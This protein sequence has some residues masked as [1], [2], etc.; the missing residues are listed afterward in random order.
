GEGGSP[1]L[2]PGTD[3]GRVCPKALHDAEPLGI[4]SPSPRGRGLGIGIE[5]LLYFYKY[6]LFLQTELP[7]R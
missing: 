2:S 4:H 1:T 5:N 6:R 7:G 3:A